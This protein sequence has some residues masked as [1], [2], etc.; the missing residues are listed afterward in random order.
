MQPTIKNKTFSDNIYKFE[1]SNYIQARKSESVIN[2]PLKSVVNL[3][4]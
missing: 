3:N 2:S 4:E 1:D